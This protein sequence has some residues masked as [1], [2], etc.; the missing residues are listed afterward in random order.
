MQ[1]MYFSLCLYTVLNTH[2]KSR[3]THYSRL[4]FSI[5]F[6]VSM[7]ENIPGIYSIAVQTPFCSESTPMNI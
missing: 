7:P 4:I 6:G 1:Q 3:V 2:V 5:K